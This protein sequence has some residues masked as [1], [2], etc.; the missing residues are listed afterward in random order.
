MTFQK[1]DTIDRHDILFIQLAMI[2]LEIQVRFPAIELE[3]Q[4][5]LE[6]LHDEFRS[7]RADE[8]VAAG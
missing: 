6:V 1:L 5:F 7:G 8:S 3:I 4:S 2:L